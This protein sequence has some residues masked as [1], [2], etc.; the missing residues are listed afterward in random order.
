MRA[1]VAPALVVDKTPNSPHRL[2]NSP[3]LQVEYRKS[4]F[5]TTISLPWKT[6]AML[7]MEGFHRSTI[8]RATLH[9]WVYVGQI[10]ILT[11]CL[12]V[13]RIRILLQRRQPGLMAT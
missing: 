13:F 6:T 12:A 4:L 11:P 3:H 9:Q 5:L 8:F 7:P 2:E 1:L 10:L